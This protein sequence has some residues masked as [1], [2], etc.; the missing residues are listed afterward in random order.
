MP[1][2]PLADDEW[3]GAGLDPAIAKQRLAEQQAR[4][5]QD[6]T[7]PTAGDRA[8]GGIGG[9]LKG[10]GEGATLGSMVGPE[11]T[12]IGA[13]VGGLAGL[14]GGAVG[15]QPKQP[16]QASAGQVAGLA[17]Q[18]KKKTPGL[19]STMGDFNLTDEVDGAPVP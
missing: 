1:L 10:A 7:S 17:G 14:V 8:A 19:G 9:A 16:V 11:G 4:A 2:T 3:D 6:A 15:A 13:A 12:A 5:A 18:F